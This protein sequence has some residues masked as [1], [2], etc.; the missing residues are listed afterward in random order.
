M[1]LEKLGISAEH[2][3]EV[4]LTHLHYDHAGGT[5]AFPR[6][7]FHIQESEAAYATGRCMCHRYLRFPF[8]VE[9]EVIAPQLAQHVEQTL[10]LRSEPS[11]L[12]ALGTQH[13]LEALDV[14][15]ESVGRIR[16]ATNMQDAVYPVSGPSCRESSCH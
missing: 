10:V 7:R 16:H 4:I 11:I 5:S 2:V 8:D 3:D 15:R 12:A 13:R 14:V 1:C 9:D 6:A